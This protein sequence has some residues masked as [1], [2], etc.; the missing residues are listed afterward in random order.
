MKLCE[1]AVTL[2]RSNQQLEND[3]NLMDL[4]IGLLV[5]N[6]MTLQDVVSHS[7]NLSKE[8]KEQLCDVMTLNEQKGG[9]QALSKEEREKLEAYQHLFYLSVEA[10]S[11]FVVLA[12][13]DTCCMGTAESWPE[14]LI[15]HLRLLQ[16]TWPS[17]F[18][19]C[20]KTTPQSSWIQPSS[21]C[22]TTHPVRERNLCCC[23]CCKQH[24]RKRSNA[25][26][27]PWCPWSERTEADLGPSCEG[28]N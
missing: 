9:L 23:G 27:Q 13:V 26:F 6:R 20:L 3:L 5:K 28:N 19:R 1:E 24:C 15:D 22:I 12:F 11:V 16:R 7:K 17:C 8:N 10:L 21:R 4:K 18:C 2:I 25:L 14:P